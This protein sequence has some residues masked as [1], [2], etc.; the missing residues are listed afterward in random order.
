MH[1]RPRPQVLL[2]SLLLRLL[3]PPLSGRGLLTDF[4][5]PEP[6]LRRLLGR[7]AFIDMSME[8]RQGPDGMSGVGREDVMRTN[9]PTPPAI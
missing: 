9:F 7:T 5:L 6:L 8:Q 4:G 3:N 2:P 1:D